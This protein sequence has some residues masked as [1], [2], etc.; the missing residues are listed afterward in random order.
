M[1]VI[2]AQDFWIAGS[3]VFF[4]NT[5]DAN[6][7][8]LD[9]GTVKT[10]NPQ[11][12]TTTV[13]LKDGDGGVNR[14][15]DEVLTDITEKYEITT[16]NFAL[17]NLALFMLANAPEAFTQATTAL[18]DVVHIAVKGP[19]RMV[20]LRN[21]SGDWL[22]SIN[23]VVVKDTT[24]ATTYVENTDWKWVSK[25]RGII[26]ILPGSAIVEG[27]S[28]KITIT[29]N[30]ISGKRLVYPQS[31]K[32]IKGKILIVWGR[33][34]NAE[35]TMRE[36]TVSLTPSSS[37]IQIDNY[38]EMTFTASILSDITQTTA[39]AGKLLQATGALPT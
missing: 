7:G 13:Q 29:P 12:E 20:K 23:T 31:G 5:A 32:V 36:A 6:G 25:D 18:T 15:V 10:V 27:A 9:L 30:A 22:Y 16:N 39:P 11:F 28:L 33:G 14:L 38:S 37:S 35:Q 4:Q 17:D 2:G 3:R 24:A 26:Q 8:L 21:A 19:G 34:G 1:A